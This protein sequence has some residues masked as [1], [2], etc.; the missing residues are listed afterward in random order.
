LV[1]DKTRAPAAV[2]QHKRLAGRLL[3]GR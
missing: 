2:A 3:A 1:L